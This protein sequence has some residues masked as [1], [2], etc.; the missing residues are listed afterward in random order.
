MLNT[1]FL[2]RNNSWLPYYFSQVSIYLSKIAL[3]TLSRISRKHSWN[4][5]H[6]MPRPSQSSKYTSPIWLSNWFFFSR[7]ILFIIRLTLIKRINREN[8]QFESQI[9]DVYFEDWLGR[10]IKWCRFQ[11]CFLDIRDKVQSAI[12][13]NK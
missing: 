11:L 6:L 2:F 1:L 3:W 9:G 8:N 12:L 4:L 5:H 13:V 7:F 10:G